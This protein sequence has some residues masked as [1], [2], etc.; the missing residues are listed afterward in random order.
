MTNEM[1]DPSFETM[2][3]A[4]GRVVLRT[5]GSDTLL[6]PVSGLSVAGGSAV[7]PINQTGRFI[8]ERISEGKTEKEIAVELSEAF[9]VTP[10]TALSDCQEI[11]ETFLEQHLLEEKG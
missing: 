3:Q 9:D 10:E 6:V 5:I 2:Y 8:W 4:C 1:K 7:F 11:T